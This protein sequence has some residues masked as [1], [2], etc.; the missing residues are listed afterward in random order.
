MF[1]VGDV[2]RFDPF[3]FK[4]NAEPKPKYFITIFSNND[5]LLLASLPTRSDHV[6]R[7]IEVKHGCIDIPEG[8][9]NCFV[10]ERGKVICDDTGFSFGMTTFLYGEEIDEHSISHLSKTHTVPGIDY[11]VC[12]KLNDNELQALIKCFSNGHTVKRKYKRM[13][14]G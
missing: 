14:I 7:T 9:F 4:N 8:C 13:L 6:P 5:D 12:G 1:S 2:I 11:N 10:F 3:Y